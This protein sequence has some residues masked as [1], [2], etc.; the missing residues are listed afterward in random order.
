VKCGTNV[1]ACLEDAHAAPDK[2]EF[3]NRMSHALREARMANYWLRLLIESKIYKDELLLPLLN[4]STEIMK[5]V[6]AI[7]V[8]TRRSLP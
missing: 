5:I 2:P 7:T 3:A 1:G 4:E 8:N 6:G